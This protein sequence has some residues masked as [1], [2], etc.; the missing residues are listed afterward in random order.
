MRESAHIGLRENKYT[1]MKENGYIGMKDSWYTGLKESG[2]IARKRMDIWLR[3]AVILVVRTA[4]PKFGG[5]NLSTGNCT[6]NA[7][8]NIPMQESVTNSVNRGA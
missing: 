2:H 3:L 8:L 5:L 4:N 7:A 1:S 6:S